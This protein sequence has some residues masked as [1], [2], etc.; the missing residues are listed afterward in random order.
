MLTGFDNIQPRAYRRWIRLGGTPMTSTL[1]RISFFHPGRRRA[2]AVAA[3][4]LAAAIGLVGCGSSGPSATATTASPGTTSSSP[5]STSSPGTTVSTPTGSTSATDP[6]AAITGKIQSGETQT[7]EA[8]YKASANGTTKTITIAA[9]PPKSFAFMI[10]ASGGSSATDLVSNGTS[11]YECSQPSG[12]WQCISLPTSELGALSNVFELYEGKYWLNDLTGLKAYA[13]TAGVSLTTSSMTVNG[14][15][16]QCVN[17]SST[18]HASENGEWCVT[19]QGI[20]GYVKAATSSFELTSYSTSVPSSTFK[21]PT[22][23][24]ITTE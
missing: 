10:P 2:G 20:M 18:T 12:A 19:A 4:L 11:T 5:G 14:F 13:A 24:T 3:T 1:E 6:L 21:P 22:G 16:L 7:F 17:F 8:T 23:A 9:A 15:S